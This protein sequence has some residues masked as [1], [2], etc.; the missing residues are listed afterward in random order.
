[1]LREVVTPLVM[2]KEGINSSP[3]PITKNSIPT[4]NLSC[5]SPHW[6]V[7]VFTCSMYEAIMPWTSH[8]KKNK[9]E[10]NLCLVLPVFL[11]QQA[12]PPRLVEG[13]EL[14]RAEAR[15]AALLVGA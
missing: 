7:L 14:G 4:Q 2:A 10:E 9:D 5:Q 3:S 11:G 8:K 12:L 6:S 1:M 15:H 13:L